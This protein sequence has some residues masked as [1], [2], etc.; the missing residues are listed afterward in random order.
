MMDANALEPTERAE[1][2]RRALERDKENRGQS[3][4]NEAAWEK[5]MKDQQEQNKGKGPLNGQ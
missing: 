3:E 2:D 1:W 4:K 5:K